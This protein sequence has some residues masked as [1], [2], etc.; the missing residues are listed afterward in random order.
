MDNMLSAIR[1]NAIILGLFGLVGSALVALTFSLTADKIVANERLA[2]I[3][4]IY[5]LIPPDTLD[6]DILADTLTI[7]DS[8]LSR[9][10]IVVF[11]ARKQGQPIGIIFSPVEA[12]GYSSII[13][14][15]IAIRKDGTLGGVRV[16]SHKETPGL[17][18]KIEANRTDWIMGF[19]NRSLGNPEAD[20]W[21]VKKDGGDFDQITGATIS[22]RA[23]VKAVKRSLEYYASHEQQ[24]Y[25]PQSE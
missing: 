20:R 13:R 8:K 12:P 2:L 9:G 16:L 25:L 23:I 6:N 22:P 24:L 21:L 17:G 19:N 15:I 7:T 18:D 10:E 5:N 4:Q 1:N 11:R 3:R 14:L